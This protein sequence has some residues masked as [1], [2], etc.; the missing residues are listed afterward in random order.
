VLQRLAKLV[1]LDHH[2]LLISWV[3]ITR[4]DEPTTLHSHK[5]TW[6]RGPALDLYISPHAVW[7]ISAVFVMAALAALLQH[8]LQSRL[9]SSS[10]SYKVLHMTG[11]FTVTARFYVSLSNT[12]STVIEQW[13]HFSQSLGGLKCPT[14]LCNAVKWKEN[15]PPSQQKCYCDNRA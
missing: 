8:G 3:L 6:A 14:H 10:T 4:L 9:A 7:A 2:D 1:T 12:S 5:S 13:P 15:R 11:I